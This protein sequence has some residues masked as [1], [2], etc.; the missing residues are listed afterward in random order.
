MIKNI[1]YFEN[2]IDFMIFYKK[3]I[4][5]TLKEWIINIF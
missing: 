5:L 4:Y 1:F 2:K 3:Y